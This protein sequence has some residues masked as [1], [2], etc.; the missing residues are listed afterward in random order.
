MGFKRRETS[1]KE[2]GNFLGY[3]RSIWAGIMTWNTTNK[4]GNWVRVIDKFDNSEQVKKQ[5]SGGELCLCDK[6]R[7]LPLCA[8]FNV[9]SRDRRKKNRRER[10]AARQSSRDDPL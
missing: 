5:K 7:A 4:S 1:L 10:G 6:E 3:V 2:L 9:A 8:E